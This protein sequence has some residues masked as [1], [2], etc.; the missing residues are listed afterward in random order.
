[1]DAASPW[2]TL[3]SSGDLGDVQGAL[4][5]MPEAQT[6][7]RLTYSLPHSQSIFSDSCGSSSAAGNVHCGFSY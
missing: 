5:I 2:A 4:C 6:L 7:F 3:L 1:M